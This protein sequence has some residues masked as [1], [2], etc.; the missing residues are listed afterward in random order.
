MATDISSNDAALR[1]LWDPR[2][3]ALR[4]RIITDVGPRLERRLEGCAED[5]ELVDDLWTILAADEGDLLGGWDEATWAFRVLQAT[6]VVEALGTFR[7]T[8]LMPVLV[9]VLTSAPFVL[10][11]TPEQRERY[12]PGLRA[13]T[14]RAAFAMTEREGGSDVAGTRSSAVRDGD[15]YVVNAAKTWITVPGDIDWLVTLVRQP[16]SGGMT[17]LVIDAKADGVSMTRT[18][19]PM[20]MRA[21]PVYDL[22][23]VDVRVPVEDRLGDEGRAFGLVMR[24]LNVVRPIVA[25]RGLGLT[26]KVLMEAVRV[27]EKRPSAAGRLID[28]QVVRAKIGD[29]AARLEAARLLTYRAAALVDAGR[30]GKEDAALLAAAKLLGT[31]LAVE[32][33]TT[34]LHLAG[35]AGYDERLPFARAL[36]DAQQLTIVEGVS[37]VQTELVARGV[38]DRS[39]WWGAP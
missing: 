20:G 8:L 7:Q 18:A 6:V 22:D 13:G 2:L 3:L 34:C 16:E 11:G 24:V 26:E 30:L 14:S 9:S 33:A 10:A 19:E 21:L 1:G 31:E 23:L 5:E 35:A 27:A 28:L 15:C 32:A 39:V 38:I 36:R 17:C 29:L 4:E 25:A 37:E 12:L